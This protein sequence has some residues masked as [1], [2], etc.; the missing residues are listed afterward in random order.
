MDSETGPA[1]KGQSWK[2]HGQERG[3]QNITVLCGGKIQIQW[4]IMMR[5]WRTLPL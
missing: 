2:T 4:E 1:K 3:G 5:L